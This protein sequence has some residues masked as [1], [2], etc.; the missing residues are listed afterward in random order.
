MT[1]PGAPKR[2]VTNTPYGKRVNKEFD[3]MWRESLHRLVGARGDVCVQARQARRARARDRAGR[4]ALARARARVPARRALGRVRALQRPLRRPLAPAARRAAVELFARARA[5]ARA[6]RHLRAR[7][8]AR[9]HKLPGFARNMPLGAGFF[10][11]C[12]LSDWAMQS[13]H[14]PEEA[15]SPRRSPRP[16]FRLQPRRLH[17][18]TEGARAA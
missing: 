10:A 16:P 8:R 4:R 17:Q 9:E 6:A 11:F 5:L 14:F 2:C 13:R 3:V 18:I 12:V 7:G 1:I 15:G